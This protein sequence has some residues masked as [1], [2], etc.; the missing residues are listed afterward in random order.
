MPG[1]RNTYGRFW[2]LS[3]V[4]VVT[5]SVLTACGGS[6]ASGNSNSPSSVPMAHVTLAK[7]SQSG[8]QLILVDIADKEGIFKKHNV[9]VDVV[10]LNGDAG[11][12]PA[13]VSGSVQFA[14]STATPFFA[15]AQKTDALQIVTPIGSEPPAQAV[16]NKVVAKRLGITDSTPIADKVK[17]LKGLKVAVQDIGGGLQYTLNA[18]LSGNGMVPKDVNLSA[19]SPYTTMLA[20]L[21]KGDIDAAAPAVPYGYIAVEEGDAVMLA[22]IWG[23]AVPSMANLDFSLLNVN[24]KY[25]KDHP[26]VVQAIKDSMQDAMD[27][28][29]SNPDGAFSVAKGL[30]PAISDG[31]LKKTVESKA[32]Y[33]TTT[34]FTAENFK[35]IAAFAK[36][37]GVDPTGIELDKVLWKK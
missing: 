3:A 22:D 37:S 6:G 17:A 24:R 15:A 36:S 11:S 10:A 5:L 27:Y 4:C 19:V 33:P 2:A 32:G 28:I 16:M 9:A 14:V 8:L 23:G 31:V 13:L 35:K 25:A 29:H 34:K 1:S 21:R 20:A 12:I 26:D 7:T 18:L 30:L